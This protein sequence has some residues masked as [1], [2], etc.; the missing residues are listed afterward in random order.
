MSKIA[1]VGDF[2]LGIAPNNS[3]KF[4]VLFESQKRFF[5]ETLIPVL[6]ERGIDTIIFTGDLY[7]QRRRIDSKIAQFVEGLFQNELKNF[8]C[9]VLQGN[10]D[11]Y[12]KDDLTITSLS[13]IWSK[14]NVTA[15]T[16]ITPMEIKGVKFLLVPWL[17]STMSQSF[18]ENVN[19]VSGKFKYVVGHFETV[20]F[21]FEAGSICTNGM[22]PDILF[23]NFENT[24]SGHFHTQSYRELNGH[25]IHYVGTPFQLTF[26]DATEKKGFH[27]LDVVTNEREFI[28]NTS[29][30][31][32]VKLKSRSDIEKYPTLQNCFVELEYIDGTTEDELYIIEKEVLS[33]NPVS[34][35]AYLKVIDSVDEINSDKTPEEVK[36]FEDMSV[37]IYSENMVSMTRV[38]LEA[39]PYDDEEMVLEVIEEIRASISG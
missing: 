3:L 13:N 25:S 6:T 23:N 34:Y 2:H 9:I 7:D 39:N 36:I 38:F 8:K 15:I 20:G 35:K 14:P 26:A 11:T 28:E 32:F 12:Y 27:I 37:A 19:K 5:T 22:N 33:K 31:R 1:I 16:K 24:I 10:H 18:E 30:S 4:E 29:S 21:P 17:T